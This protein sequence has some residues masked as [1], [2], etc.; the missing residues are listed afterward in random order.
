MSLEFEFCFQFPWGSPST[1]LSDFCQLARS[2]NERECKQTLTQHVLRVMTSLL[3]SSPPI[4]IL[5]WLFQC[6][7]SN[8][9]EVVAS[10]FSFSCPAARAPRRACSQAIKPW[11]C[12]KTKFAHICYPVKDRRLY[13]LTLT[14]F[15]LR[16]ELR[17]FSQSSIFPQDRRDRVLCIMGCHLAWVSK[18]LRGRGAVWE[19][20]RKIEK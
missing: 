15:V 6:R 19:E 4:S 20:V 5:H 10:S 3:M 7:Y 1:E 13:F 14:S 18:V 11:P 8:S 16:T 12:R 9:K 17:T 2:G